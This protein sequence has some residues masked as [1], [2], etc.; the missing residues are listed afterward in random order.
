MWFTGTAHQTRWVY[1]LVWAASQTVVRSES[2]SLRSSNQ[3]N[4]CTEIR[5]HRCSLALH[6]T[7]LLSTVQVM[8]IENDVGHD[9]IKR[10]STNNRFVWHPKKRCQTRDH[11]WVLG[12]M[13]VYVWTTSAATRASWP[14]NPHE[15][16]HHLPGFG[17]HSPRLTLIKHHSPSCHH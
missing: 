14:I 16:N 12:G 3:L 9:P 10:Y 6:C 2:Q 15:A 17:N 13:L 5:K 8:I 7:T 1:G 4:Q 11:S